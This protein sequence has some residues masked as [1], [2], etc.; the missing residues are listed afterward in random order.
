MS[1]AKEKFWQRIIISNLAHGVLDIS[2]PHLLH[3]Q[4]G[5]QHKNIMMNVTVKPK[6]SVLNSLF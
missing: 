4:D 1:V 3:R 6:I 5:E 2:L